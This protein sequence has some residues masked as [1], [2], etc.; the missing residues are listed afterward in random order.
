VEVEEEEDEVMDEV[1]V[2]EHLSEQVANNNLPLIKSEHV[3]M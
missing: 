1:E 3:F 2:L